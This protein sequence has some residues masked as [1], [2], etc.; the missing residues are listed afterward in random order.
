[1]EHLWGGRR[2][3]SLMVLESVTSFVGELVF[4]TLVWGVWGWTAKVE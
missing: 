2:A 3:M 1:M 4:G